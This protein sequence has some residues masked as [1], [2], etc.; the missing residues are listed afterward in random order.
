MPWKDKSK[1][2]TEAYREYMRNYQRA[3]HQRHRAKRIMRVQ[4]RRDKLREFYKQLKENLA[5]TQCGE[6]HPATLQFHH[7]DP[8]T[9][10][11]NLAT[12]VTEGY[13]IKRIKNEIA[14]CIVLCANC[15]AKLHYELARREQSSHQ[16]NPIADVQHIEQRSNT[17][18]EKDQA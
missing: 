6:N 17:S 12:V 3:W 18:E 1:Y 7:L 14:K 5:C 2:Q 11:F 16:D 4:E 15:H 8:Q 13:S 9:K 10:D